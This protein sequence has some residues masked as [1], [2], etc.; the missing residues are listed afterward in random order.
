MAI[1]TFDF[2]DTLTQTQWDPANERFRYIGPNRAM[3]KTL[4]QHVE[5]EDEAHII[6]T[7]LD[8]EFVDDPFSQPAPARWL[9]QQLGDQAKR[10]AGVH[11]TSQDLK[12]RLIHEL[13]STKHYDDDQCEID[14][15]PPGCV[16]VR[17]ATLHNL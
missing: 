10:L 16:G 14:A 11:Y 6:V 8:P 9:Q 13:G 5:V 17:V 4:L 15:L 2:D 3:L 12:W 7:R 1:I